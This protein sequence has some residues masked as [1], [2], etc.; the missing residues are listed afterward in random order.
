MYP[1]RKSGNILAVSERYSFELSS[2]SERMLF[3]WFVSILH[4]CCEVFIVQTFYM[5]V[6]R[7]L[8]FRHQYLMHL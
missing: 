7:Y 5:D 3:A 8:L 2:V 4:G 1:R 6:A